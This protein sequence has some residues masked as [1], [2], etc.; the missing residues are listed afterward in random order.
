MNKRTICRVLCILMC[1]V[2]AFS[3]AGCRRSPALENVVY[4]DNAEVDPDNQSKDN[5]ENN[6]DSD[7]QISAK[8]KKENDRQM[9]QTENKA[10]KDEKEQDNP[11]DAEDLNYDESGLNDSSADASESN[12]QNDQTED[13]DSEG[14][15]D[16]SQEQA[17]IEAGETDTPRQI[18]DAGGITVTLPTNVNKVCAVGDT[19]VY[20]KMLGGSN[21]LCATSASVTTN[22]LAKLVMGQE[23]IASTP[24]LWNGT[25]SAEIGAAEFQQLITIHPEAILVVG[26]DDSFSD[27]Q[28]VTLQSLGIPIVTLAKYNTVQNIQTN[29]NI[30]AEVLG[31]RSAD[32]DGKK[33]AK[34]VAKQYIDWM[35]KIIKDTLDKKLLYSGTDNRNF[36]VDAANE[37][38]KDNAETGIYTLMINGWDANAS[39]QIRSGSGSSSYAS[40]QG[41]AFT[42]TGFRNTPNAYYLSIA[43]VANASAVASYAKVP[44]TNYVSPFVGSTQRAMINGTQTAKW[45]KDLNDARLTMSDGRHIGDADFNI[46]IANSEMTKNNIENDALWQDFGFTTDANGISGYGFIDSATGSLNPTNVYG[47]YTV[48]VNPCGFGSWVSGSPESPLEAI[49]AL[50]VFHTELGITADTLKQYIREFYQNFY[51]VTLSEEGMTDILNGEN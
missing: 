23:E 5:D 43:G 35:N 49:W 3:F 42:S 44:S 33:D 38:N 21:R 9:D 16:G 20:V 1:F 25:G 12:Q 26:A 46:I 15:T 41:V 28:L 14:E 34:E 10:V 27:E 22:S 8:Q 37:T 36:G 47:P 31:D 40:G 13:A 32:G 6:T 11:Q 30:I 45:D 51:G 7:D 4:T 17:N 2:L 39:Y 48:V 29:I 24:A 18:V 50:S 19:A